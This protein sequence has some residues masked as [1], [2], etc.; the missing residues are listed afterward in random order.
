MQGEKYYVD[1]GGYHTSNTGAE[2][3]KKGSK[4]M[5]TI[6][7]KNQATDSIQIANR[8][9]IARLIFARLGSQMARSP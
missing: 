8:K 2:K 3:L 9:Q 5:R 1:F 7:G 4:S 6:T